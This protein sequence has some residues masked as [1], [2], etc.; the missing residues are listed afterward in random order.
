MFAKINYLCLIS[1]IGGISLLAPR[2]SAITAEVARACD[3]LVAKNFPPRVVGNPAA[4][5]AKGS[6]REQQAFFQK[7]VANGGKMDAAAPGADQ[8]PTQK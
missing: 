5:S 2:A 1:A 7:C 8:T 4:G 6:P 3:A